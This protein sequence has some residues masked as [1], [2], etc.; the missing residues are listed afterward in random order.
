M[1]KIIIALI[2]IS[3]IPIFGQNHFIGLKG[4]INWTSIV[5]DNYLDN[6]SM[7]TGFTT[8]LT[9]HYKFKSFYTIGLDVLYVQRGFKNTSINP[10]PDGLIKP[11]IDPDKPLLMSD[12]N[13]DYIS[14]PVKFG[15]S[16]G[17]KFSVYLNFGVIP[18][19]IVSAKT[20]IHTYSNGVLRKDVKHKVT[21]FDF[22]G[23]GEL[24]VSYK[25]FDKIL[26]FTSFECQ[27]S[28]TAFSNSNY[29]SGSKMKHYGMTLV[30]GIKYALLKK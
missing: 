23:L 12:F 15:Y 3:T 19:I 14:I 25:F 9:Y 7:R 21:S 10:N 30:L 20:M 8:G 11:V 27:Y 4:G 17:N 18:S 29:Y 22:A 28:F 16:D 1:R 6:S 5:S 2:I 24:G 26:L 13:Y